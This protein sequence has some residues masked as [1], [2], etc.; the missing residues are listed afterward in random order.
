MWTNEHSAIYGITIQ[1]V[2]FRNS[3]ILGYS[4]QAIA[5][6]VG[7]EGKSPIGKVL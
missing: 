3:G 2:S 4:P 5:V 7:L 6:T 1:I